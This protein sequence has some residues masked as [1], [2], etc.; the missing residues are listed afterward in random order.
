MMCIS[1]LLIAV[2]VK[3]RY[4]QK[5]IIDF[6]PQL[7]AFAVAAFR[8]LPSVGRINE[9]V[10]DIL[11]STASIEL[12]YHDLKEVEELPEQ[13]EDKVTDWKLTDAININNICYKY[14]DTETDVIHNAKFV[15]KKGQTVAFIGESGA[16]KTTK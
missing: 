10:T 12:V 2:I 7:A 1:G 3:M 5:E 9:H 4:G 14:P 16:G 13:I 6:I 8:L 15:I 11:Y